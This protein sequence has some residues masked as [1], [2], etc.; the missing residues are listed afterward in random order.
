MLEVER[1][2]FVTKGSRWLWADNDQLGSQQTRTQYFK[3][4]IAIEESNERSN[5]QIHSVPKTVRLVHLIMIKETK[6][7]FEFRSY[8]LF[9]S[10][11]IILQNINIG[12]KYYATGWGHFEEWKWLNR[13]AITL[14]YKNQKT[15]GEVGYC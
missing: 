9:L 12:K 6:S 1:T 7:F 8:S 4:L 13:M 14:F 11:S 5:F 15:W 10:E 2:D 3:L